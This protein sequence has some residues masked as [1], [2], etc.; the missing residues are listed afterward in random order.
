MSLEGGGSGEAQCQTSAVSWA[1]YSH[2]HA[3]LLAQKK[4]SDLREH[5]LSM[6][7]AT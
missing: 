1:I 7:A 3:L 4:K 2:M 6:M 5:L